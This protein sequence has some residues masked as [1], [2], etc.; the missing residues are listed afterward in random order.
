MHAMF[1]ESKSF[2]QDIS[3]WN[4]KSIKTLSY[5]LHKAEAY[6][7]SLK[8]WRLNARYVGKYYIVEYTNI[9]GPTWYEA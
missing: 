2:N 8:S 3:S 9:E 7:Y 4:I 6:T 1:S 5:F